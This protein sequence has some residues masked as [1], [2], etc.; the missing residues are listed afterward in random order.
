MRLRSLLQKV[1]QSMDNGMVSI[2]MPSFNSEAYLEQ[3]IISVVC[4]TYEEWELLICDDGSS[5]SSSEIAKKWAARDGRIIALKNWNNKGAAGARNTCLNVARGRYIAF[6]DSDDFWHQSKLERQITHMESS[7]CPFSYSYYDVIDESGRF[8][9][10]V[11]TPPEIS[12]RHLSISNFIPCLTV[13]YDGLRFGK[14]EQPNIEKRN[15]FALWLTIF[16]H[17]GFTNASCIQESLASYRQ[18]SYGLSSGKRDAL[19]YFT[20]CLVRYGKHSRLSSLVLS[21]IYLVVIL[22]KKKLPKL[23][24]WVVIKL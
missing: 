7:G 12:L 2:L 10:T 18:N 6:L 4:Q 24:N 22:I 8:L 23:Y 20:L 17:S 3:A 15:D 19:R 14:V 21:G 1:N 16:H 5:D 9:H 13:I 11:K